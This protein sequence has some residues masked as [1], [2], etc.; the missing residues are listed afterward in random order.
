MCTALSL[1]G[2]RY[3]YIIRACIFLV[4]M[5]QC[6]YF[7][8]W[9]T[10]EQ[11]IVITISVILVVEFLLLIAWSAVDPIRSQVHITDSFEL[12][13][14]CVCF[15]WVLCLCVCVCDCVGFCCCVCVRMSVFV[16][17]HL[18]FRT[19]SCLLFLH[20]FWQLIFQGNTCAHLLTL[21]RGWDCN[22]WSCMRW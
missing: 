18:W 4:H 7:Y 11:K 1:A 2:G 20:N 19:I 21:W 6:L 5:V 22:W 12:E 16:M 14:A 15:L 3:N 9:L 8:F 17:L 13:G 10:I